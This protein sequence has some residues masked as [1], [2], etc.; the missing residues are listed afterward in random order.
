MSIVNFIN[1]LQ[2]IKV[3][4]AKNNKENASLRKRA[5]VIEQN[6]TE[7]LESKDQPGV[8]F[9]DTAIIVD[10]RQKWSYKNKKDTEEDSLRILEDSGVRNPKEVLDELSKARKGNEFETKKIKI[11][12]IKTKKE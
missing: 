3:A 5:K 9:Q 1:E 4:I 10:K 12:K 8:K 11:K 6:I 7:Y 2:S